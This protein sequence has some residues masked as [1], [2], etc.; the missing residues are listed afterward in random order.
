MAGRRSKNSR[1][2]SASTARVTPLP[3]DIRMI[4]PCNN[5]RHAYVVDVA[6]GK[7]PHLATDSQAFLTLLNSNA[8]AGM[9]AR[10]DSELASLA[11]QYPNSAWPA[12]HTDYKS[13]SV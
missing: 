10:V 11:Q 2:V 9:A 4:V 5:G 8:A 1:T 12:V 13:R 6:T 3:T 7:N